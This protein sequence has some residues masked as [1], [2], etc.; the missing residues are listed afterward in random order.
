MFW[1]ILAVSATL[2]GY[3]L[4][5]G[6]QQEAFSF[7]AQLS[8][9][10]LVGSL[11]TG[12]VCFIVN[13][14]F[15]INAFVVL[16]ICGIEF[17]L[18]YHYFRL[19]RPASAAQSRGRHGFRLEHAPTFY[20]FLGLTGIVSSVHLFRVYRGF[21]E[22]FPASALHIFDSEASFIASVRFGVNKRRSH[23]LLY[24]DPQIAGHSFSG[25]TVPLLFM[26]ALGALGADYSCA[27]FVVCFM[28]TLAS[29]V[30]VYNAAALVTPYPFIG[31]LCFLFNGGWASFRAFFNK[32]CTNGD[33]VHEI[34]F[35]TPVPMYQTIGHFLSLSKAASYSIPM[36]IVSLMIAHSGKARTSF[37]LSHRSAGLLAALIPSPATSAGVFLVASCFPSTLVGF[38]PFAISIL[39]KLLHI[40]IRAYPVWREYQMA[41][42]FFSAVTSWWDSYGPML[43]AIVFPFFVTHTLAVLH[44]WAAFVATFLLLEFFR[45]GSDSFDNIL[46]VTAVCAPIF[47]A[48]F[49]ETLAFLKQIATDAQTSG[50]V[51]VVL[52]FV[53]IG[54]V[55]G[56]LIS[57]VAIGSV[58]EQS[59]GQL[60]ADCGR[61]ILTH[62]K[63]K[64]VIASDA[65][66]LCPATVFA[67]RQIICGDLRAMWLRDANVTRGLKVV[68]EIE[69]VG[70]P[71][72]VLDRIGVRYF[73][74]LNGTKLFNVVERAVSDFQVVFSNE[75]WSLFLRWKQ[76]TA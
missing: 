62:L 2:F 26:T 6:F 9:A 34:C 74:L 4:L 32:D 55:S 41:G 52:A 64:E 48:L 58:H 66:P 63:R 67:G 12:L 25:P 46:A 31:G 72:E 59:A 75:K 5:E 69:R 71:A 21:P 49:V 10:W 14:I 53:V 15:P 1:L 28:N 47:A 16:V 40:H 20:L 73:L 11:A 22:S 76:P 30:L 37:W 13:L 43:I 8:V 36:A 19:I 27:S 44:R 50:I 56:G 7:F 68:R 33:W 24:K 38:M 65:L 57:I 29:A 3:V 45:L 51:N 70:N 23:V 54:F 61:W 42:V 60:D 17:Y 18:A 39:P 35:R